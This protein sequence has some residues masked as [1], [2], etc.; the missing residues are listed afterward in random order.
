MTGCNASAPPTPVQSPAHSCLTRLAGQE[1][2]GHSVTP[3]VSLWVCFR[4]LPI[5]RAKQTKTAWRMTGSGTIHITAVSPQRDLR[6]RSGRDRNV[7]VRS[8]GVGGSAEDPSVA[9][10]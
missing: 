5:A 9:V 3:G 6:T 7:R 10:S 1:T 4:Q 2:E 8:L